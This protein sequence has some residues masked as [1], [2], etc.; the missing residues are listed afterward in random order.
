[1]PIIDGNIGDNQSLDVPKHNTNVITLEEPKGEDA[2]KAENTEYNSLVSLVQTKFTRAKDQRRFDEQRWLLSYHNYRGIYMPDVQFSDEEKSQVFMKIT[3]TKVL[4]AYNQIVEILFANNTFPIGVEESPASVDGIDAV[5]FDPQEVEGDDDQDETPGINPTVARPEILEK[6]GILK[7]QLKPIADKLEEGPGLTPTSFTWEPNKMAAE[8]MNKQIQEQLEESSADKSIRR[9]VFDMSLFGTGIFKGPFILNKEYPKWDEE[10]NYTPIERTVPDVNHVSIWNAYPDPDARNMDEAEFFIQRHKFSRTD[11]RF[12]KKRPGFRPL[13]IEEA[14]KAGPNYIFQYW[15]NDLTDSRLI[16]NV[17]R[18]EVFEYWGIIDKELAEKNG[19]DLSDTIWDEHDQVQVNIWTCGNQ[20]LRFVLNQFT[21]AKIPFFACP[22]ELNPYSF[23]GV[24][25]AENMED[26]QLIMNGFMRMAIDNAALSSNI[27]FEV[28]ETMLTPGQDMK[29]YPGKIFRRNGGQPGQTIFATKFPN[30]TQEC[31]MLF[32]KAR[33]LADEAT[34]MPSYSH[35]MTDVMS[36]GRTASGM[37]MLMG[38]AKDN[39]KGVIRNIDDYLLVPLGKRLFAFNMQFNFDKKFIGD[40]EIVAKGV[41]SLLRTE[42]R[43]Q[44]LLQFMQLS[45]NPT[46]APFIKRDYILRE[47][48]KTLDLD[49]DKVVND[50]REAGIQASI[51]G[52]RNQAQGIQPQAPSGQAGSN[53]PANAPSVGN[54]ASPANPPA[55]PGG[56]GFS[57]GG[58]GQNSPTSPTQ[59]AMSNS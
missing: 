40:V 53:N 34:G 43:G 6:L 19:I 50:P 37:Q 16:T 8:A 24:G 23:F 55:Q 48:A 20:V 45:S 27:I 38:A 46:D 13:A 36:T 14:I 57:G 39:I 31:M 56:Q 33:Q 51:M 54:T 1:M 22:Y 17:D 32:D 5:H 29:L 58:G 25:V 59:N 18:F 30:V 42:V 12:L 4:A 44:K 15:E 7:D 35:G 47:I 11:L 52:Q 21:P 49:P 9:F 41:E 10:G 2:A 3:K 26:T 28:D